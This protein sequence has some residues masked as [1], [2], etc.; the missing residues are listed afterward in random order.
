MDLKAKLQI[1]ADAAKYDASCAS[2]GAEKR[3]SL[4]KAGIG[5]TEGMG[6]CH[7]YTPDGRCV[8]LLK[9]LL[10]NACVYDCLYCI[11]R[12]SSSVRRARFSVD[13]LVKLMLGFYR[14]NYIE[15]LF[16]SS[17]IIRSPDYT[18]EEMLRVVPNSLREAAY[19]L[20]VPKWRTI[21]KVVLPTALGGIVTG[22]V[23]SIARIIGET[24]P[25]LITT[26]VVSSVNVNPFDGRMNNLAVFAFSSYKSPGVPPE[27]SLDRAWTAAL[28][29]IGIV[30]VLNVTARL[31]YRRFGTEIR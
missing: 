9:I 17:G 25:L 7:S 22:V 31:V 8:S 20:G 29:L 21:V 11:N 27:P 14:R 13:E 6:I 5:S 4:G 18:M 24:A 16:L 26:G 1:L 12:S 2:S 15:G 28:V 10:T 30:L 3:H 19:A 23:L